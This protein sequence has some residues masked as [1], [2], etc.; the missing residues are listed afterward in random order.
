MLW[1]PPGL[2]HGVLVISRK[3]DLVYKCTNVFSPT[4]ERTLA[5]NDPTVAIE[6]PIPHGIEPILSNKD[7]KGL[8]FADVEKF[9]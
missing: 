4:H 8:R 3:A 6:W 1:V 9:S 5:W 2:A 7:R